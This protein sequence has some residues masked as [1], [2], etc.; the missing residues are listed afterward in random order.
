MFDER[1]FRT[2]PHILLGAM[3]FA[4][5]FVML[6]LMIELVFEGRFYLSR[7]VT[8]LGGGAFVGYVA[9]A[10][11]VRPGRSPTRWSDSR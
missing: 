5:L 3:A 10:W 6:A 2:W 11:L 1:A 4:G 9:T 7:T 8:G